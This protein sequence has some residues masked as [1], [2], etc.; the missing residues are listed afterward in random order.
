MSKETTKETKKEVTFMN[1]DS[2]LERLEK[3]Q[4]TLEDLKSVL[5]TLLC[6]TDEEIPPKLSNFGNKLQDLFDRTCKLE[7]QPLDG[8]VAD[9]KYYIKA[10]RDLNTILGGSNG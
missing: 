2:T 3:N 7:G 10:V 4:L 6:I 8:I 5:A 1:Y 9:I